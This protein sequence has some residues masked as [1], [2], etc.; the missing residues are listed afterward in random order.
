MVANVHRS[1]PP[2]DLLA[3]H[4]PIPKSLVLHWLCQDK[5]K[6]EKHWEKVNES[7]VPGL[8]RKNRGY[9]VSPVAM[10]QFIVAQHFA[11][12]ETKALLCIGVKQLQKARERVEANSRSQSE[13]LKV[14]LPAYIE[15]FNAW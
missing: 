3:C 11:A 2:G 7:Q 6:W 1:L 9:M 14:K 15:R 4:T 8:Q 10:W 12:D 13:W 5:E